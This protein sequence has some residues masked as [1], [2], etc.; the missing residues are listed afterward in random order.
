MSEDIKVYTGHGIFEHKSSAFKVEDGHLYIM[1]PFL[2]AV[3]K[4]YAPNKWDSV[5]TY[6]SLIDEFGNPKYGGKE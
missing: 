4:V 3:R 6:T 5:E 2:V 1:S